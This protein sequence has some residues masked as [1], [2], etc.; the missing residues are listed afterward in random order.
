MKKHR[1]W[2]RN[3]ANRWY[4]GLPIG[5]GRLG[6]MIQSESMSDTI[7]LTESTCYSGKVMD[8]NREGALAYI[9]PIRDALLDRNYK[10]AENLT[11]N[12]TGIRGNYGS[13]IPVG[14]MKVIFDEEPNHLDEFVRELVL[15]DGIAKCQYKNHNN[16]YKR[17]YLATNVDQVIAIKYETDLPEGLKMSITY[18]DHSERG[19]FIKGC[20]E[21][22]YMGHAREE[23][24]SDGECGVSYGVHLSVDISEGKLEVIDNCIRIE[25][26]PSVIVYIAIN[27]TYSS[28]S[29]SKMTAYE[30]ICN[31]GEGQI[32][33]VKSKGY[34]LIKAAHIKDVNNLFSRVSFQ[35]ES[36]DMDFEPTDLRLER[37]KQ[38]TEDLSLMTLMYQYGR[39]LLLSSSRENSPLPA[40]L[41][42]VWND[43]VACSIG[44]TCDMHLDINT[45]MNYWPGFV[46][47]LCECTMPLYDWIENT[48]VPSGQ[49]TA[50]KTY[51]SNGWVAHTV[52]NPWGYSAPGGATYWG[53]HVTGGAWIATH[54][55]DYYR[56]TNNVEFLQDRA[57]PIL[58]GSARFLADNLFLD[59]K[60]GYMVTGPSHSPE[61]AFVIDGKVYSVDLM[62]TCDIAI[63]RALFLACIEGAKILQVDEE[64]ISELRSL[65]DLIPPYQ[66][67]E[68][69]CLQE[70]LESRQEHDSNHRHTSHLLSLYPFSDISEDKDLKLF[71]AAQASIKGR[72]TP[73]NKW[74]DTGWARALMMVYAARLKDSN[75][76]GKHLYETFSNLTESNLMVF[77]PSGAGADRPVY[78]LDGNT[79]YTNA[80]NE[81]LIQSHEGYIHI[82]PSIPEYWRKGK[83]S[84]L[85][86]IG[87]YEVA[88]T[89]EESIVT[90]MIK[91]KAHSTVKVRYKESYQDLSLDENGSVEWSFSFARQ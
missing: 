78:E 21:L 87:D 43:N 31:K 5:N 41:Q 13:N 40:H 36:T 37:M 50:S 89:F 4:D 46:S 53:F 59:P 35:L 71:K 74:E 8:N 65:L 23:I 84:G 17:T 47:N 27:T 24:H 55:W 11:S 91:G 76:C 60:T 9:K 7:D 61:N 22:T 29:S 25:S 14:S 81:M 42:G 66:I 48:L 56:Y 34:D 88:I 12:V 26:A 39:Y 2:Y 19:A 20:S 51:G 86:C 73:E 68:D 10:K 44:W 67:D 38:G 64:F 3:E 82:L 72:M 69:G 18:K 54:L 45:Q 30:D 33:Q 32:N 58:K 83:V 6:A 16:N 52:S 57:Y 1:I 80:V 85:K 63:I 62:P 15:D 79:G 49:H 75:L 77:H 90:V 28:E 70:W